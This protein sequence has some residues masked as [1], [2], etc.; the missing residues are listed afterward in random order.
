MC[1][2]R[3]LGV[4]HGT[5]SGGQWISMYHYA[6]LRK[7]WDC[8]FRFC[9]WEVQ[10][11]FKVIHWKRFSSGCFNKVSYTIQQVRVEEQAW[12]F[13]WWV[14]WQEIKK[15]QTIQVFE[16]VWFL[17]CPF[18]FDL[19]EPC[20]NYCR[21]LDVWLE[22]PGKSCA[23]PAVCFK[24]WQNTYTEITYISAHTCPLWDQQQTHKSGPLHT[25]EGQKGSNKTFTHVLPPLVKIYVA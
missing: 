1:V 20:L 6:T 13:V 7:T 9:R 21:S 11:W 14:V 22:W 10:C 18:R 23:S 25:P 8:A 2:W 16:P 4:I 12:S 17:F 15:T 3:L 24:S 5:L 19:T